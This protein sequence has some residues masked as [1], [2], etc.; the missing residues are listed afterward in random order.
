MCMYFFH[1]FIYICSEEDFLEVGWSPTIAGG[2]QS[3]R[4][5]GWLLWQWDLFLPT[6]RCSCLTRRS[7]SWYMSLLS[8]EV[9][10]DRPA[11]CLFGGLSMGLTKPPRGPLPPSPL[12]VTS[13]FPCSCHRLSV[14][15]IAGGTEHLWSVW[16][17]TELWAK[18]HS[19]GWRR[20]P[21]P[22]GTFLFPVLSP[23]HLP[24]GT[25]WARVIPGADQQPCLWLFLPGTF[26]TMRPQPL[27]VKS[28]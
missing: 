8:S 5:N 7:L 24:L 27:A 2:W 1:L 9:T 16:Q 12:I 4:E 11:A 14:L 21:G 23:V 26:P 20:F 15:S 28:W 18:P 6:P 3:W 10:L 17:W 22:A 13:S 19:R 25:V